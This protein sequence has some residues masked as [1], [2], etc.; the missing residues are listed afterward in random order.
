MS[1]SNHGT[2]ER[3]KTTSQGPRQD[4]N[5]NTFRQRIST[6]KNMLDKLSNNMQSSERRCVFSKHKNTPSYEW[7]SQRKSSISATKDKF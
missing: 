7:D 5:G 4:I 6:A 3:P 2:I 1:S